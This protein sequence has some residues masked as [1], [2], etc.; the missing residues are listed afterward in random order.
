MSYPANMY[1]MSIC[2]L[3]HI[4]ISLH[5]FV[6]GLFSIFKNLWKLPNFR[7][8]IR[9][10]TTFYSTFPND[11]KSFEVILSYP[12]HFIAIWKNDLFRAR[13]FRQ[14]HNVSSSLQDV[15]NLL[16]IAAM[17]V[18]CQYFHCLHRKSFALWQISYLSFIT[19]P[20]E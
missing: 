4:I 5:I 10:N 7:G 14:N 2:S 17:Y 12:C 6:T 16:L 9:E 20:F 1:F 11:S 19:E 3:A 18:V 13:T 8:F 15:V